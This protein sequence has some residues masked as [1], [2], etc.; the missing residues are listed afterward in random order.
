M[1]GLSL[2]ELSVGNCVG[3]DGAAALASAL[4]HNGAIQIFNLQCDSNLPV[5]TYDIVEVRLWTEMLF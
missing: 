2:T 3:P 1:T 5:Y 4:T